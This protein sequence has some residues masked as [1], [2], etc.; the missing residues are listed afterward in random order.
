M[1]YV[2]RRLDLPY[3]VK[4]IPVL[5]SFNYDKLF[6]YR[7]EDLVERMR[8]EVHWDKQK[9]KVPRGEGRNTYKFRTSARAPPCKELKQFEEDLFGMLASI[10]RRS[11]RN[12]LQEKM[13][14]DLEYI[15]SLEDKVIV[16]SD[17]TSQLYIIDV[18]EYRNHQRKEIMKSYRKV[19][20]A[21]ADEIDSEAASL[22]NDVKLDDRIE[23]MALQQS[24]LTLKDHK[25][26]FPGKLSFRLINPAKSNL[27]RISKSI[28]DRANRKVRE[29]TGF[30]QW[31]STKDVL[32]WFG[33]L[34]D[35]KS[36]LWLK[37]DIEAFYP[38]ITEKLLRKTIEFLRKFDHISEYEEEMIFHCRRSVLVDSSGTIWQ[39]K[40]GEFD[41]TMGSLDGAEVAEAV[42]LY[43]LDK[44]TRENS[45]V[46]V[47]LY[48]DDGLA[49]VRGSKVEV[50]RVRKQFHRILKEEDLV[51]TTEGG[52]KVVDFLD[53]VLNL[54]DGSHPPYVKPNTKTCYVS[55]SSNHPEVI[56]KKI[57]EGVCK[58]LS[59]NSSDADKFYSHSA[60]F[61]N[62]LKE[63]GHQG[64]MK[65]VEKSSEEGRKKTRK[66]KV[67]WFNPPWCK[68]VRTNVAGTFLRLVRKHFGKGTPL[69]HLFNS[70][71]LKVSYSTGP[72]M[73]QIISA[74]NKRVIAKMEGREERTE[75][76][77]CEEEQGSCPTGGNCLKKGL[78]YKATV[79]MED[80]RKI[81]YGQTRQG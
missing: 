17:K 9:D 59:N 36:L 30:Q 76:C 37:F 75:R 2:P 8:W 20:Q 64:N 3:S 14:S 34:D 26:D 81:Y 4:N 27:G 49:A 47:G 39:K 61:D 24:F 10:E 52:T 70:K 32:G 77:K 54:D 16:S 43:L 31:R 57:Q 44:L 63:A 79:N 55:T 40:D 41:V 6:T 51:I 68:S 19:S 56:I 33:Q 38:S 35:K 62:A 7:S 28:L 5:K 53:V 21:I 13:K 18:E 48:R 12:P 45:S 66:R 23:G 42:G 72:N 60:H 1:A 80:D 22:A 29:E 74:H 15:R 65:Y 11:F 78:V 58:R 46:D 25:E 50:E 73:K 71:K 67:I 69:Y